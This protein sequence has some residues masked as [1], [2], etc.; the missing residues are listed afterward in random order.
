MFKFTLFFLLTIGLLVTSADWLFAQKKTVLIDKSTG[1]IEAVQLDTI[2]RRKDSIAQVDVND[3]FIS[4]FKKKQKKEEKLKKSSLALLPSIG[5]T[6]STGFEFGADVSGTMYLGNPDSTRLSVFDAFAAV[7]TNQLAILQLKHNIYSSKNEWNLQGNWNLGKT[8]VLDHGI[9]TEREQPETFPITY[10]YLNLGE[11]VYRNIFPNF[12]AGAGVTFNYYTKID[13]KLK[14]PENSRTHN[15]VYSLKN[16]YPPNDYFANGFVVN[17]Q[18]NTRDQPYRPYRGMYVDLILRTNR[19]WMGS[20]H[21]A[22]QLK[23][24]LR[25]YWSLSAKNPEEVLAFWL[26]GSYLLK[27]SIPYLELPGTGSDTDQRIGRGYTISRFKGPSFYYNELEYR[28]PIT[29]NKLLS[30]V[31]FFN[32]ETASDQHDIKLFQYWEPGGGAGLRILFNKHTRSNLCIDYGIGNYS[33]NGIFV[34]LNEVF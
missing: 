22:V 7:S 12:Y 25:K 8:L 32:I 21:D 18:Y 24:E 31:A 17:L 3:V 34:G 26:W 14:N 15:T 23:T 11:S 27:G 28:F 29:N 16:G 33:S 19:K 10:T 30:G 1:K 6:P 4:L 13:D 20:E 5:Y 2:A 9:G